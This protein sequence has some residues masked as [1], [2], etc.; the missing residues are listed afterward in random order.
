MVAVEN[1]AGA[2]HVRPA[3]RARNDGGAVGE[4]HQAGIDAE[5]AQAVERGVEAFFLFLRLPA[6]GVVR[7]HSRRREVGKNAGKLEMLALRK[8]AGETLDVARRDAEAV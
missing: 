8:L 7:E 6:D 1:R 4:M 5:R 2:H 3:F